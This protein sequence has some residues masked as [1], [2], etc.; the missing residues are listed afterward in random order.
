MRKKIAHDHLNNRSYVHRGRNREQQDVWVNTAHA[1]VYRWTGLDFNKA[2][3]G[4]WFYGF[5]VV[6]LFII[7]YF[8]TN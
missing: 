1:F 2:W 5:I 4:L 3:F 7:L 6:K 8:I